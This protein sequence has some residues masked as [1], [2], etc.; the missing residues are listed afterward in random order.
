MD[1]IIQVIREIVRDELRALHIG[2]VGTVTSV[3]PIADSAGT[4]NYACSVKLRER[5]V[6]L[7]KVP[8]ATPHVGVVS[9]P[10]VDDLVLL[11]FIGG[12]ANAP[13]VI[14]RL[15]SESV[16]PPIH[17]DGDLVLESPLEGETRLTFQADGK[18]VL[19]A[20]DAEMVFDPEEGN[21]TV[22]GAAIEV[23]ASGEVKLTGESD[24]TVAISGDAKITVDGDTELDTNNCT[25]K[26]SGDI[27]L[28]EGGSPVITEA[29]HKC[30][31][32]GAPL[33]GSLTVKAKG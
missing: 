20:G 4:D 26:A 27:L 30:Y 8:I 14:G 17:E 3:F 13:V 19:V 9:C 24:L 33:V 25:V 2:E 12:D 16:R 11:T 23:T 28:G 6:E 10:Q 31:F 21:I 29:S 5:D 15:H 7:Q 22:S 18:V 1:T 32:T